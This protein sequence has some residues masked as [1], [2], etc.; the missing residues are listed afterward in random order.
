MPGSMG[1][2]INNVT[3]E[4]D[5]KPIDRIVNRTILGL[6]TF[7]VSVMTSKFTPVENSSK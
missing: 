7:A 6:C 2:G 5:M 3:R 4:L 1:P